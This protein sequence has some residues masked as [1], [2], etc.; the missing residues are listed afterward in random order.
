MLKSTIND[1]ENFFFTKFARNSHDQMSLLTT[2]DL[3][4]SVHLD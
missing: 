2:D 4:M 1:V 3:I